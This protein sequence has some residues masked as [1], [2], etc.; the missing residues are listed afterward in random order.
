MRR[1]HSRNSVAEKKYPKSIEPTRKILAAGSH[2]GV[3]LFQPP[4]CTSSKGSS[5][6]AAL[7]KFAQ[8][9]GLLQE[10]GQAW[11]KQSSSAPL[12]QE[13]HCTAEIL[14]YGALVQSISFP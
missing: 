11:L 13:S 2:P 8:H 4:D 3:P 10:E 9:T 1:A 6:Y 14:K 7:R 12:Y 5:D